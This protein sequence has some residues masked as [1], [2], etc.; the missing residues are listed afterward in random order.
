MATE[1]YSLR[2]MPQAAADLSDIFEYI[3]ASLHNLQS[4]QKL[5]CEIETAFM[6]LKE[7]PLAYPLCSSAYLLKKNY[8]KLIV[9]NYLAFYIV[10]E[11]AKTVLVMRILYGRRDYEKLL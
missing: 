5:M 8:R 6:T 3:S 10:Q 11:S 2:I 1:K 4:A 7:M 9:N